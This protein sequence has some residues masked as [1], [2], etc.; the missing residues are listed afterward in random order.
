MINSSKCARIITLCMHRVL[1]SSDKYC[2]LLPASIP[3]YHQ[4]RVHTL[5]FNAL[6][7]IL[8]SH[9]PYLQ[10]VLEIASFCS[11]T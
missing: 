4:V 11:Q 3:F 2:W 9:M 10:N 8:G 6:Q 7:L 5:V 1:I